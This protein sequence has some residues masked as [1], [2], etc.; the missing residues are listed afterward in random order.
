M[1][2]DKLF[3]A[4]K[5]VGYPAFY[6]A[7]LGLFGYLTFPYGL[8]KDRIVAEFNASQ[9]PSRGEA[10]KRL[11]ID[12]LDAYWF[13]GI[14]AK[15]VRLIVPPDAKTV[16]QAGGKPVPDSVIPIDELK[17]R[18]RV[19]PLFIGRVRLAFWASAFGGEVEGIAPLSSRGDLEIDIENIELARIAFVAEQ[20]GV[21]VQGT[22]NGKLRLSPKDGKFSKA[23]GTFELTVSD[24]AV[25]DGKTKVKGIFEMPKV[26]LGDLK[27]VG[28]AK[29]GAL[30]ISEFN[31]KG[32]DMELSGEGKVA[33][34][35]PWTSSRADLVFRFKFSDAFRSATPVNTMLLG[36]PGS[37]S[38]GDLERFEPKFKKAKRPDGFYGF[39]AE[40]KLSA[41]KFNPWVGD[42]RPSKGARGASGGSASKPKLSETPN[43]KPIVPSSK[44]GGAGPGAMPNGQPVLKPEPEPEPPARREPEEEALREREREREPV[45]EMPE[46]IR[47]EPAPAEEEAVPPV[48][49]GPPPADDGAGE[50]E[51]EQP[52]GVGETDSPPP[53]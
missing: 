22:A 7:C 49:R 47:R 31:A 12:E 39:H 38:G 34:R 35:E 29:D 48:D 50:R 28:E 2:R 43:R 21:P 42:G 13:T 11:E 8:L 44:L 4:L 45:G 26:N 52:P 37:P 41:M 30:E 27:L 3:T 9:K 15:G 51:T 20:V 1:M 36:A 18:V 53:P 5:W 17:A 16:L 19:L 46:Q 24:V 40:G 33:L 14:E 10:P 32:K 6:F 25:G 23:S